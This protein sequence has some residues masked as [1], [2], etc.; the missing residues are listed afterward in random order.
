MIKEVRAAYIDGK[1]THEVVIYPDVYQSPD[2]SNVGRDFSELSVEEIFCCGLKVIVKL[3]KHFKYDY[4]K[5]YD[6]LVRM[7]D[8][9]L[10]A[11]ECC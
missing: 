9:T 6:F 11:P 5:W 1:L 10:I 4:D 7:T 8:F 2:T 3:I